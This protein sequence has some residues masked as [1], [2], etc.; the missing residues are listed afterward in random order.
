MGHGEDLP[1]A[2]M[3]S[4]RGLTMLTTRSVYLKISTIISSSSFGG[5]LSSGWE[6]GWTIPFMSRYRLSNSSPL[7]LGRVVS[8]GMTLPSS[9]VMA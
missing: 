2:I 5:G 9:M 3:S 6:Q 1:T 4:L 8:T 7:G